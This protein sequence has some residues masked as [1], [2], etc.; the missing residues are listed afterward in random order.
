MFFPRRLSWPRPTY[1]AEHFQSIN[2]A[3]CQCNDESMNRRMNEWMNES[4][5]ESMNQL[6]NEWMNQSINKPEKQPINL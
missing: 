4:M 5:N 2:E 3:I 6:M 1:Q